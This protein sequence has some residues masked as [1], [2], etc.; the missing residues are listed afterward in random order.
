MTR[1]PDDPELLPNAAF[2]LRQVADLADNDQVTGLVLVAV[3][4]GNRMFFHAFV[5]GFSAADLLFQTMDV[6]DI[7]RAQIR[8][9]DL[10]APALS[11]QK[12]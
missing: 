5:D 9:T 10:P 7:L 6:V 2:T 1:P 3:I 12:E 4:N 8:G 11:V